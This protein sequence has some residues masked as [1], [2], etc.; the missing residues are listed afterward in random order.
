MCRGGYALP[1]RLMTEEPDNDVRLQLLADTATA[2]AGAL[3]L[4]QVLDTV[5]RV[6]AETTGARYAALGVVGED[7]TIKRFITHGADEATIRAI[8]HYPTGKGLLGL[9]IREPRIIRVDDLGRHPSSSGFPAHHP[10]MTTFLGAPVRSG[11]R[12]YGNLYLTEKPGGFGVTDERLVAVLAAQ[13]GSAIENALLSARLQQLAVS[14]E[15]ERISRELHDSVIQTLFSIGMG[16]QSV[17]TVVRVDADRA[18]ARLDDAVDAI[19]R[20]IRELRNA[21]FELRP[22]QAAALG[23]SRGL[24]ELAREHEVNALVRPQLDLGHDLDARVP[25]ELVHDLLAITR[26]ALANTAKHA[27]AR[28]VRLSAHA[29]DR[30]AIVEVADDGRGFAPDV[31]AVGRGLDTMH[32]RADA[33]GG[34]LTVHSAAGTGTRVCLRVPLP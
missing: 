12:V 24:A 28:G 2:L 16:L 8:G 13:A 3:D 34:K 30:E 33:L 5:V 18:A 19:D 21:I 32:E 1:Y 9:L 31:P 25:A 15:R 23:L 20:T 17:R 22:Q 29:R 26:E 14:E 10:P 11:G 6:A 4:D 7:Q 27:R